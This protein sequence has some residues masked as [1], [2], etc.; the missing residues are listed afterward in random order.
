MALTALINKTKW[1][2]GDLL[3]SVESGWGQN[4]HI[5]VHTRGFRVCNLTAKWQVWAW[6]NSREASLYFFAAG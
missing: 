2:I 4:P 3:S 6:E 5:Y 1:A